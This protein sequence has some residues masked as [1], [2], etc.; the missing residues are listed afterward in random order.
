MGADARSQGI[1]NHSIDYVKPNWFVPR[2]LSVNERG[3]KSD[4]QHILPQQLDKKSL[5]H[6]LQMSFTTL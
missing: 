6:V 4:M 5:W 2:T 1:R 3:L